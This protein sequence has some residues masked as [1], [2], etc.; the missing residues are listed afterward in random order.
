[1][2]TYRTAPDKCPSCGE[3]QD[4]LTNKIGDGNPEPGSIAI[5]W[6]C[7]EICVIGEDGKR[8]S[9]AKEDFKSLPEDTRQE[10]LKVQ[11]DARAGKIDPWKDNYC[12]VDTIDQMWTD[13]AVHPLSEG[14]TSGFEFIRNAC[15]ALDKASQESPRI[16]PEVVRKIVELARQALIAAGFEDSEEAEY[17]RQVGAKIVEGPGRGWR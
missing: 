11:S 13:K 3:Q 1:M 10:L 14:V 12:L 7:G 2:A 4:A 8:A 5:C 15:M 17:I 9:M 6:K 16:H